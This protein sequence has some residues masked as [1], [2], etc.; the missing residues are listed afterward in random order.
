[1][2]DKIK[3]KIN[4]LITSLEETADG[5]E[6]S[7]RVVIMDP[8]APEPELRVIGLFSDVAEEKVA[9]LVHALLYLD[10]INKKRDKLEEVYPKYFS[11]H[12]MYDNIMK[13]LR[14]EQ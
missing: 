4:T 1:M 9:E 5:Q 13:R 6:G 2:I 10:D 12:G 3:E 8:G 11:M 14:S 7:P